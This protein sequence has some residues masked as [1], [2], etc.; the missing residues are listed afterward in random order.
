[1][2]KNIFDFVAGIRRELEQ[3]KT[4][5]RGLPLQLDAAVR[6]SDAAEVRRIKSRMAE[7]DDELMAFAERS[8][9]TLSD[10]SPK[11]RKPLLDALADAEQAVNDARQELQAVIEGNKRREQDARTVLDEAVRH[12]ADVYG[13]QRQASD[14]LFRLGDELKQ[15]FARF[16]AAV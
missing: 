12:H 14:E 16:A 11:A 7:L 1:M 10:F 5:R 6:G 8:Q 9:K 4:E 15:E 2:S 13:E 3:M